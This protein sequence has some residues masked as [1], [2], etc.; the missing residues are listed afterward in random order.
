MAAKNEGGT[1]ISQL[2]FPGGEG[3]GGETGPG[4]PVLKG[5]GERT[6]LL[7]WSLLQLQPDRGSAGT[8][9]EERPG[10]RS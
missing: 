9:S 7:L 8:P 5:H 3:L 4:E 6:R 10:G 1:G 2:P